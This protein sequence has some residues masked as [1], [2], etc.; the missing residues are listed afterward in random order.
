MSAKRR[1]DLVAQK[2]QRSFIEGVIDMDN[3]VGN[4]NV[5]VPTKLLNHLA[6]GTA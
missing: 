5:G 6:R 1:E 3:T 2:S 4:A